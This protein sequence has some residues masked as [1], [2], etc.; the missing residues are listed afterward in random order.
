MASTGSTG[1]RSGGIG[2]GAA[3]LRAEWGRWWRT[4][5]WTDTHVAHYVLNDQFRTWRKFQ[6]RNRSEVQQNI[7]L[8]KEQQKRQ[9]QAQM[10]QMNMQRQRSRRGYGGYGYGGGMGASPVISYRMMQWASLQMRMGQAEFRHLEVTPSML[11]IG[12]GQVRSRRHLAA[13]A[14]LL[15][16][17]AGWVAL[18]WASALAAL[19]VALLAAVVFAI[20]AAAAGRSLKP[21]RP[22]V[23]KLLFIPPKP[24]A[25]T[26]LA[27]E[28]EPEPFP[29]REAGRDPRLVRECVALALRAENARVGHVDV[30]EETAWGWKVPIVLSGGTLGDL[31]RLLPKLATI[32]RVGEGRL[33]AQRTSGEDSAAVTLRILTSDPFAN[34]QPFPIR[35]PRSASITTEFSI[36]ISIDGEH[37]PIVL[38]GQ[39]VLIVA[40][41]GGGKSA[42]VRALAEF[43]TACVDA[44]AIDIDPTGRGLGPLA[45]CAVR[46]ARTPQDAEQEL[47]Y[48][49][50]LAQ[51][52][53]AALGPTEDN[54]TV[55]P[56]TPA[57]IAFVD[58]FPQLTKR[59]KAAA[60]ALLRIGRKARVTLV[61]CS[62]DATADVM[63]DAIADAFGVRILMPCRAADV[64]L[65]VGQAD[66]IAKGWLPHLLVPSPGDWE[67]ADAGRYYCITPRH[68]T[69]I[70][71]YVSFLDAATAAVRAVDRKAAGLPALTQP[72]PTPTAATA[73]PLPPIVAALLAAFATH[74]DPDALSV[75]QI[76]D[77]LATVDPAVW[78]QWD[79]RKDR[80]AL[81]GRR[82]KSELKAAGLTIPTQRI[83]TLPGRP[84]GYLLA[85]IR[86]GLS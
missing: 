28:P 40:D 31:I 42:M 79:G 27:A 54:W 10:M 69:P 29:I 76:T 84:T 64:P 56:A 39:N 68:R 53:I 22:P 81:A 26:E 45:P 37:T 46:A 34:P 15:A 33:L 73:K 44:V 85:D 66:A 61:V 59:G 63:G 83:D 52:R 36:G 78:R 71:R 20:A 14:W 72:A 11:H 51:A 12:R 6:Q 41:S 75:A 55:T 24:P 62:Q 49:L 35:P 67:I 7:G 50:S 48:L 19:V 43:A 30:P 21:R 17:A 80:L 23:P 18:W 47:E 13:T 8:L 25:N 5:D 74:S 1:G 65:V 58:E 9:T 77:H 86:D 82:I 4:E 3:H 57:V 2:A 60:L 38:A 16:L 32:L 70:L